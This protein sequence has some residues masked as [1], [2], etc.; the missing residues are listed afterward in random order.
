MVRIYICAVQQLTAEWMWMQ[1]SKFWI[2]FICPSSNTVLSAKPH[3]DVSDLN[4]HPC[5]ASQ[6][7]LILL[8]FTFSKVYILLTSVIP[9]FFTY[10]FIFLCLIH[11]LDFRCP[12]Y[13]YSWLEG[14]SGNFFPVSNISKWMISSTPIVI[15]LILMLM[16]P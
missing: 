1:I 8:M 6:L 9:F 13:K 11:R 4:R 5:Q 16:T 15:I 12:V 10:S 2:S 3:N 14:F 7:H